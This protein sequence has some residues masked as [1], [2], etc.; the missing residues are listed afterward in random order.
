MNHSLLAGVLPLLMILSTC[1]SLT[2]TAPANAAAV[3]A[4]DGKATAVIIASPT[5]MAADQ[6][7][8]PAEREGEK[9]RQRVR[10]SIKDLAHY[11]GALTGSS[12]EI[13][14]EEPDA[15]DPRVRIHVGEPAEK[16]FGPAQPGPYKQGLRVVV[17]D[18][19]VGLVGESPLAVSYA[20]Y[21]LLHRLGVRWYMPGEMGE[22]VPPVRSTLTLDT[23]DD[24]V[25]PF[26]WYRGLWYAD[27][28]YRRRNRFGG[29][30]LSAGHALEMYV[31]KED[32]EKHPEWRATVDG[33]P[34]PHRLKWS[35][36]GLADHIANVIIARY[37]ANPQP[38]YSLSPDDGLGYDNSPEDL[39]LDADDFDPTFSGI[40]NTDRLI[41]F[42]NQIAEKVNA[43]YPDIRFGLLAYANY[44]RPPVREKLHP[45][46]IPQ[47]APIT[48]RRAHPT[49]MPEVPGNDQLMY[50]IQGWGKQ[51]Q[52]MSYYYYGWFLAEP[53]APNPYLTKWAND[54]PLA[55]ANSCKFWQP[56]TTPNFETTM[57]AL[58]MSLR[59]AWDPSEKPE[60]IYAEINRNF[61]GHAAKEM[62]AYWQFI[63]HC[64][65]DT[66]EYS[67]GG[68]AYNRRWTPQRMAQAR[69]LMDAALIA[70][71]NEM[72]LSRVRLADESLKLFELFMKIRYDFAAGKWADLTDDTQRWS[73]SMTGLGKQYKDNY[74]FTNTSWSKGSINRSYY[75]SFYLKTYDDAARI[76]KDCVLLTP[77]LI[78]DWK[79][80]ADKDDTGETAGY[81]NPDFSDSD[82]STTDVSSEVWSSIGL[83]DYFGTVWYRQSVKL[84]AIPKDKKVYLWV[85]STDGSVKAFINGKVVTYTDAK[86]QTQEVFNGFCQPVSFD[87][88][89][90]VTPGQP[91][92]ITL[93]TKRTFFNE[94]GTGGLL[95]PV[96]VYR[97][98]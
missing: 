93:Q 14:T 66:P 48:Y 69:S 27:D 10:E 40:S 52:A 74:T 64:W 35:A 61:Y 42:T 22:Y 32:R 88:T 75:R 80:K 1:F 87:I 2:M 83:H 12:F 79:F 70:C 24:H 20:V 16:R 28:A 77:R 76:Q 57:H 62:T 3:I 84:P 31:S 41:W 8:A 73:T 92:Q 7:V 68:F 94:L 9:M 60:D 5:D 56:E 59:L 95:S 13:L 17:S 49:S 37:E 11:L 44:T 39:A 25:A 67:G 51:A 4:R 86:D 58:Y 82:W 96:A 90:H 89:E 45:S 72:E 38:T 26:T 29:L 33:K 43:R 98:K 65:V 81:A 6:R 23:M 18:K 91:M 53:S 78:S 15:S 46:I 55:M 30:L 97:Q 85:G 36:P 50:I 54:V 21:E 19:G 63:D 47:L 34:H 71:S